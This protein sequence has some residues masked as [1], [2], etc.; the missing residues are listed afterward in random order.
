MKKLLCL[1]FP[2][3]LFAC[4]EKK[5]QAPQTNTQSTSTSTAATKEEPKPEVKPAEIV[6]AD[7]DLSTP[8]DFEAA[9]ET[10]ITVKN[11]KTE[12]AAIEADLN[13]E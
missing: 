12:L 8:A 2:L 9:A 10:A 13:K 1:A 5:D 4:E 6:I 3:F 11:Y 7:G